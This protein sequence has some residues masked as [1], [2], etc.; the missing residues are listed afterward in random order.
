MLDHRTSATTLAALLLALAAGCGTDD[1]AP[2]EPAA[3]RARAVPSAQLAATSAPV[4]GIGVALDDASSRLAGSLR[5]AVARAQLQE[6]LGDLAAS[7]EAGDHVKGLR[8]LAL[9]RKALAA[10]ERDG[11]AADLAVISLALDRAEQML[12]TSTT[13]DAK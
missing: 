8:A 11:D 3:A 10:A 9:A 6:R 2:S 13:P 12:T 4:S 7:L 5:D 1:K